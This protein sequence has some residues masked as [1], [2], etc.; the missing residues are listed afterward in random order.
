MK[1]GNKA[2]GRIVILLRADVVKKTA[3]LYDTIKLWSATI[4]YSQP[5]SMALDYIQLVLHSLTISCVRRLKYLAC[6]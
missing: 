3:G 6:T 2:V 5:I 4:Y 1:I